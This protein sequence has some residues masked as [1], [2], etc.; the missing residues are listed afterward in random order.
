MTLE[1]A[2]V[3]ETF[4]PSGEYIKQALGKVGIDVQ[5]RS[6]DLG[7]FIKR[8]YSDWDFDLTMNIFYAMPDPTI[9]VQRLYWSQNI[10]KGVPFSNAGGYS[11][12]EMDEVLEASQTENDAAKRKTLFHKMQQIAARDV[13]VIDLFYVQFVTI[14]NK[15]VKMHT[16]GAEGTYENFAKVYLEK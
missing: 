8:V 15:Q 12:A 2:A 16:T 3:D 14:Y 10:K 7:G 9:G 11:N 6:I 1:V 13:P 4:P 5:L